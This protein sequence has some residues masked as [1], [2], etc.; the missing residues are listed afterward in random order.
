MERQR[1]LRGRQDEHDENVAIQQ[2]RRR[3]E[4]REKWVRVP[5]NGNARVGS[6]D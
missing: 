3:E 2:K 1:G 6:W 4:R 5:E